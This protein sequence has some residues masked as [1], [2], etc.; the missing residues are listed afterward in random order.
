MR[1]VHACPYHLVAADVPRT[2]KGIVALCFFLCHASIALGE[3]ALRGSVVDESNEPISGATVYVQQTRKGVITNDAGAF[4]FVLQ[5]NTYTLEVRR[6]G[7]KTALH[8]VT[9][10]NA[11]T[12]VRV[13]LQED[14]KLLETVVVYGKTTEE[15]VRE[16]AY[17]VEVV[18]VKQFANANADLN[19]ILNKVSGAN[20]RQEGGLGSD[21][22]L[23]LN[24][25]SGK[26]VRVYINGIP[27]DYFGNTLALYNYPAS[28]VKSIEVY[29]GVVPI[30][31][32]S[33]ALGGAI[34]VV[35]NKAPISFIDASYA[36]GSFHSHRGALHGQWYHPETG[37]VVRGMSFYNYAANNYKV[38]V[39]IPGAG[40]A[41]TGE[42]TTVTRFH[43]AYRSRMGQIEIGLAEKSYADELMVG[44]LF[45][46]NYKEI[47]QSTWAGPFNA[48]YG[49]VL[50]S[51]NNVIASLI[52]RKNNAFLDG[53]DIQSF[54]VFSDADKRRVDT[55]SRQYDWY[56]SYKENAHPTT[57]EV[58]RKSLFTLLDQNVLANVGVQYQLS[59]SQSIAASIALNRLTRE[60][61]DKLH[62]RNA[63]Q[64]SEPSTT[65]KKVVG[66]SYSQSFWE[67]TLKATLFTKNYFYTLRTLATN[68]SGTEKEPFTE[69]KN[70]FGYGAAST[71]HLSPTAQIKASYEKTIRYP[72]PEELFGDGLLLVPNPRLQ[73]ETSKNI[74]LGFR[75]SSGIGEVHG[76]EVEA[77]GFYRN[78]E[79]FMRTVST[80]IF[81]QYINQRSVRTLGIEGTIQYTYNKQYSLAVNAT[82]QDLRNN[83]NHLEGNTGQ[84]DPFKGDRIPNVPYVF[85][86][87]VLRAHW[88]DVF[89]AGDK[90]GL[91][92]AQH[93]VYKYFLYWPTLAANGKNIIPTQWTHDVECTYSASNGTYNISLS[94]H[95][96]FDAKVFDNFSLQKPGRAWY[97]KT[98]YFLSQ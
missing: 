77:N 52:Y 67:N 22:R 21:F 44:V 19:H 23:S 89:L 83:N 36:T 16:Q 63:T 1:A 51:E 48:P 60:G 65:D 43:D 27:M 37:I 41:I 59:N 73:P 9:L 54:L 38:D 82:Y 14:S 86:N 30:H 29:K 10:R 18:E 56:G 39:E 61:E 80:G 11:D 7:F 70:E 75:G 28:L 53:L 13:Q 50:Q 98:R 92:S 76:L 4:R 94:A 20:I 40:G 31:L 64:F 55:S 71:Y 87:V 12:A 45:A 57:G 66:L 95:N 32:S 72:E 3:V 74:N 79:G 34:N 69:T 26:Q 85:G 58:E 90:L 17:N 5:S 91:S 15:E 47:Q 46:D 8:T 78:S 93:Y 81:S 49:E 96:I 24:G 25:L 62:P 6:L 84:A 35:T 88:D 33:D 97:I 2:V 68:Y 42:K